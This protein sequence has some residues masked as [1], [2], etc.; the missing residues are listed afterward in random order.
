MT[1]SDA[2]M[3]F[4]RGKYLMGTE[5]SDDMIA[6]VVNF[7]AAKESTEYQ[8]RIAEQMQ[9]GLWLPSSPFLMNAGTA[10]SMLSSCFV[11]GIPDDIYGIFNSVRDMAIIQKWGGGTG[12]NFSKIREKGAPVGGSN[13]I[14]SGPISFMKIFDVATEQIKQGGKRRGAN[15]AVL[16]VDHPDILE[17]IKLKRNL[18]NMVNFNV[19]VRVTDEFM[20]SVQD[21]RSWTLHSR[22]GQPDLSV[23]ARDLWNEIVTSAWRTGDPGLLFA[24]AIESHNP[25]PQLG[26]LEGVNPCGEISLYNDEACNLASINL[27]QFVKDKSVDFDKLRGVVNDMVVFLDDAISASEYPLEAVADRV[28]MTRKMGI[29]ITGLHE[30]LIDLDLPYDSD[31]ARGMAREIMF[32]ITAQAQNASQALAIERGAFPAWVA[33][34]RVPKPQRNATLTCIAPTGTISMIMNV[35]SSGCEPLFSLSYKREIMGSSYK[36]DIPDCVVRAVQRNEDPGKA[37]QIL[38]IIRQTGSILKTPASL[39]TC[40]LL[41]TAHEISPKAHVL[42]QSCLQTFTDNNISKTVNLKIDAIPADVERVYF[43]AW[44]GHC[45]GVTVFVDGCRGG[46]VLTHIA[47]ADVCPVCGHE[48]AH[49]EKCKRCDYCGWSACSS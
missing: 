3:H 33:N 42:M 38:S 18:A 26:P 41:A 43:D 13:G 5:D 19:S 9:A 7:V 46:Q 32:A 6:R 2:A 44:R 16:D 8:V 14:A 23:D 48:L 47:P 28:R 36:F 15:I 35:Q 31:H 17:F 27:T 12:F 45:H 25:T 4:M 40:E 49:T 22:A 30:M 21:G 11:I 10:H 24:D 20:K 37:E 39:E 29:G 1:I 34:E